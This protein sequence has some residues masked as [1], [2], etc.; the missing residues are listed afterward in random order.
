MVDTI[1]NILMK[2]KN[3]ILNYLNIVINI[4]KLAGEVDKQ[5]GR[6]LPQESVTLVCQINI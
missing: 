2:R 4:C 3:K 6:V 1:I 5:A